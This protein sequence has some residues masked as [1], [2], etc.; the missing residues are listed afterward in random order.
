MQQLAEISGSEAFNLVRARVRYFERA[1]GAGATQPKLDRGG[2]RAA[3][4]VW[5]RVVAT[6]R[7]ERFPVRYVKEGDTVVGF[8]IDLDQ[9]FHVN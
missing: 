1:L 6:F 9:G 7:E 8:L 4:E 3:P 5:R 2:I